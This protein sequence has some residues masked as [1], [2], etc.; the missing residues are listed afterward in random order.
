MVIPGCVTVTSSLFESPD[1][2]STVT[3]PPVPAA[4]QASESVWKCVPST[5]KV[6][7]TTNTLAGSALV[8]RY[9]RDS[10]DRARINKG[11]P[12]EL[13]SKRFHQ[14][15]EVPQKA[16]WKYDAT[17]ASGVG[18]RGAGLCRPTAVLRTPACWPLAK[19]AECP[20]CQVSF[21]LTDQQIRCRIWRPDSHPGHSS[22]ESIQAEP[23]TFPSEDL[24]A[25][26]DPTCAS[27]QAFRT[28]NDS[29]PDQHKPCD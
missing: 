18:R 19:T 26:L 17:V 6:I 12:E 5:G 9:S 24:A 13:C 29:A 23:V 25:T 16:P 3:V 7:G 20:H 8:S 10:R 22:S 15:M 4:V 21:L 28:H 1:P 11:L 27:M 14:S 2:G